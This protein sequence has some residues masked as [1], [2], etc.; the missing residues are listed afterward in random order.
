MCLYQTNKINPKFKPNKKNGY[1]PPPVTNQGTKYVPIPCGYCIECKKIAANDWRI[2][3]IEDRYKYKNGKFVT[4]TYSEESLTELTN[5]VQ[6]LRYEELTKLENTQ[7]H[8]IPE[9][10][11]PLEGYELDNSI[12]ALAIK[13]FRERFRKKYKKSIRHWLTC[14]IGQHNTE[15]PHLHGV[16][17]VDMPKT[18]L[19][20]I[21]QYGNV[22]EKNKTWDESYYND[23]SISYMVKYIMKTDPVHQTYKSPIFCSPGIGKYYLQREGYK[24]NKFKGTATN[25]LYT[26][27]KGFKMALPKYYR[28][29]LY[30]DEEK[31]FLWKMKTDSHL[32]YVRGVKIDV[33][34]PEGQEGYENFVKYQRTVNKICGYGGIPTEEQKRKEKNRRNLQN[35]RRLEKENMKVGKPKNVRGKQLCYTYKKP[36]TLSH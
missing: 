23:S 16:I 19:E 31:E 25:E 10:N 2:R 24:V 18:K 7:G 9:K 3:L 1:K 20:N 4:L 6:R 29:L 17:W 27:R 35:Q 15:R 13:R 8:K 30:T 28:D 11:T 36:G 12:H 14:E 26:N 5:E 22:N 32:K 34:T 21:W 33:S